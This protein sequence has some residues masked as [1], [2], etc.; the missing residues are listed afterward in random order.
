MCDRSSKK[1]AKAII[2]TVWVI[3][4]AIA[5]PE[6]FFFEFQYILDESNG[7]MKPFC[8][9]KDPVNSTGDVV[10]NGDDHYSSNSSSAYYYE[11]DEV[12]NERWIK[13]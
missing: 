10:Y 9:P 2:V 3:S 6:L 4:A 1:S 13:S 8:M 12:S 5:L 7:G 11:Y